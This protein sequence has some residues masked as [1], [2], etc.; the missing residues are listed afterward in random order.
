[1][2]CRSH[3]LSQDQSTQ[4][5]APSIDASETQANVRPWTKTDR[6]P[7]DNERPY[8]W[9]D[10]WADRWPGSFGG[11]W[12]D[13]W[14]QNRPFRWSDQRKDRWT[15]DGP[16]RWTNDAPERWTSDGPV[17]RSEQQGGGRTDR[18]NRLTPD[19]FQFIQDIFDELPVKQ[20][21][22]YRYNQQPQYKQQQPKQQQ[23]QQQQQQRRGDD[24]GL[25]L[26]QQFLEWRF[27]G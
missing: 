19:R 25:G 16:D 22:L 11:N 27:P 13:R 12:P 21:R 18:P 6:W 7:S 14:N 17:R 24:Q 4:T 3:C 23:Q 26:L 15:N 8:N 20:N 5:L 10:R 2:Y 1:M 9:A